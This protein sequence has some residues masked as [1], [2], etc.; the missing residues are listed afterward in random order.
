MAT[1]YYCS[2]EMRRAHLEGQVEATEETIRMLTAV[3]THHEELGSGFK[4]KQGEEFYRGA[5]CWAVANLLSLMRKQ[6]ENQLSELHE[7]IN[8][9]E[10]D[11]DAEAAKQ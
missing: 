4:K 2:S 6:M 8:S 9:I 5:H 11:I 1:T 10:E 3:E 7:R